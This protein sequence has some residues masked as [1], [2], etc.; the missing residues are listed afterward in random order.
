MFQ[1]LSH[2]SLLTQSKQFAIS[3]VLIYHKIMKIKLPLLSFSLLIMALA[4]CGTTRSAN[5]EKSSRP[6]VESSSVQVELSSNPTT[7]FSWACEIE[8]PAVVE[9]LSDSYKQNPAPKGM[10]GVGGVQTFVFACKQSGISAL[11]FTYRRPWK[12]GDTAE[13]RHAKIVVDDSL[14]GVV[15]FSE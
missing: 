5:V 4:S 14:H 8:N 12:G 7:G 1:I 13:I 15:E 9:I 6:Q 3:P 2:T 11:T 10:V